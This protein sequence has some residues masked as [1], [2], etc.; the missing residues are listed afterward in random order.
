MEPRATGFDCRYIVVADEDRAILNF[1]IETLSNDGHAVFQAYDG[2]S[3]IRLAVGLKV[4][5]LVISNTRVDGIASSQIIAELRKHLPAV[6]VLYLANPDHSTPALERELPADVP[7]LRE[8]F[9][10]NELCVVVHSLLQQRGDG[11]SGEA[12]GSP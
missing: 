1:V 3:A 2:Q 7:I 4:C 12:H 11:L 6:P 8:P 9:S 10:A 5:D